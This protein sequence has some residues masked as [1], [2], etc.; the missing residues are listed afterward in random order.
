MVGSMTDLHVQ[1]YL[2]APYAS[3]DDQFVKG[4]GCMQAVSQAE[5]G[6]SEAQKRLMQLEQQKEDLEKQLRQTQEAVLAG[7]QRIEKLREEVQRRT[8]A[9]TVRLVHQDMLLCRF[10]CQ[11][12]CLLPQRTQCI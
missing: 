7:K 5:A 1:G 8:E 2:P 6:V 11:E 10:R 3:A 4:V 9:R 12:C